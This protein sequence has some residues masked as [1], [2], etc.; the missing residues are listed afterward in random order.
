MRG[1]EA[2]CGSFD[3]PAGRSTSS[4]RF[5]VPRAAGPPRQYHMGTTRMNALR[6]EEPERRFPRLSR[7]V[8]TAAD[9]EAR[10]PPVTTHRPRH[11][12]RSGLSR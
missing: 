2:S 7:A 11:R 8:V 3:L 6:G 12:S 10:P 4:H 9:T 5:A 1:A